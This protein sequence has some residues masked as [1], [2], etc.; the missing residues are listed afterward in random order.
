MWVPLAKVQIRDVCLV[1]VSEI[2]NKNRTRHAHNEEGWQNKM[3]WLQLYKIRNAL[4]V[5]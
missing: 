5:I 3:F 4:T 2:I 1:I